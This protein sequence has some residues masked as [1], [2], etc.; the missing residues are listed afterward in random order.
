MCT[1]FTLPA[2]HSRTLDAWLFAGLQFRYWYL[3]S[4]IGSVIF[5][6]IGSNWV[7]RAWLKLSSGRLACSG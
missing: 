2:L 6:D 3:L 5:P 4:D 7:K 1:S